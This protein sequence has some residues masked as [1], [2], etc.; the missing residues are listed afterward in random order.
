MEFDDDDDYVSDVFIGPRKD[1]PEKNMAVDYVRHA[2][3][4][5]T[6]S[7]NE[8]AAIFNTEL[9]RAVRYDD[10]RSEAAQRIVATHK[11]HGE[12]V[13][14]VLQDQIR[15]HAGDLIAGSIDGTSLLARVVG[16]E[17]LVPVWERYCD[18][19]VAILQLG[20][21]IACSS[22]KPQNEPHLQE[23]CDGIL[24]SSG[25][26]LVR[27]FPF[28]RWS[29][30]LTKPDWYVEAFGMLIEAKYVRK[31]SDLRQISEAVAAD[32]TKYGDS[33]FS[34]VLFVVYDPQHVI[35]DEA[36]F[37]APIR[38]RANMRVGFVR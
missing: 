5:D 15:K 16:K 26:D 27:E 38:A 21:P 7:E 29:S 35:S 13:M 9:T 31:K 37:A 23:I 36:D 28:M 24:K 12:S 33:K 2:M 34:R 8:L 25:H 19:L 6:Q 20:L 14:Q 3:E 10:R 1:G 4:L 32:I 30:A 22:H 17:H 11:R 18:R